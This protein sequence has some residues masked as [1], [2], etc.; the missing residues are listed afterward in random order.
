MLL[1][2]RLSKDFRVSSRI[3]RALD[4]VSLEVN[5]AETVTVVGESG[6]GKTTLLRLAIG[7]EPPTAGS[8]E[9]NGRPLSHF[10]H[11]DWRTFRNAVQPVF[12]DPWGSLNPR[13]RVDRIVMEPLHCLL[14]L[15]KTEA[16][17]RAR[18]AFEAVGLDHAL[19]T[20]YPHEFSGGQR[21]RIAIARALAL[22][23]KLVVL[24][25]PVSALDVSVRAQIV[26]L[27]KDL[28][29][30]HGLAYL[31]VSHDMPTVWGMSDR[32]V[33]LYRGKIM[34]QASADMLRNAALSPYTQ[35][36][37]DS[38]LP[39]HPAK[40]LDIRAS[41]QPSAPVLIAP[42]DD[43]HACV[44][45]PTCPRVMERCRRESPAL[46]QVGPGHA[47]A[48]HLHPGPGSDLA[49]SQQN[50]SPYPIAAAS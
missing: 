22:Q 23:P 44:F 42:E 8:V 6:S 27:L 14:Q 32:I 40:R 5:A 26:N 43:R 36:L 29:I 15:G 37:L 19:L 35:R 48:C 3:V 12:Q 7:I 38:T 30:R 39:D 17:E 20:R 50:D 2:R 28:Q 47:V 25:E 18:H 31:L 46:T 41:S 45:H 9:F 34:E 33:V 10:G 16:A 21:Q 13:M 4:D 49:P 11:D 1:L 24:D